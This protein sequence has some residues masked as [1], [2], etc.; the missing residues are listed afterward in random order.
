MRSNQCY[1]IGVY[2]S[3][4]I[5]EMLGTYW[6]QEYVLAKAKTV[7]GTIRS[8]YGNHRLVDGTT[9][10]GSALLQEGNERIKVLMDELRKENYYS[11]P[12]LLFVG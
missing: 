8:K 12:P 4:T 11:A 9:I 5:Q 10:D 2:L 3:P 6:V 1:M 7:I